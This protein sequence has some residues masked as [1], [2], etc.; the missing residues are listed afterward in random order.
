MEA[1][2]AYV[3]V[4]GEYSKIFGHSTDLKQVD[5]L[6]PVLFHIA[7]GKAARTKAKF[8]ISR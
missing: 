5:A 6:S 7:M 3:R 2:E 1:S 4:D 8:V